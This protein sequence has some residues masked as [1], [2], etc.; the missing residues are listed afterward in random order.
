MDVEKRAFSFVASTETPVRAWIPD[1]LGKSDE[2]GGVRFIEV[3]EV[4]SMDSIDLGRAVVMPLVDAH[5]TFSI[6]SQLGSVETLQ[7]EVI[8]GLGRALT[9][10]TRFVP[11][12]GSLAEAM[13]EGHY[14]QLSIGYLVRHH[15][16][17]MREGTMPLATATDWELQEVSFAAR[18]LLRAYGAGRDAESARQ[19]GESLE[20]LRSRN[21]TDE[22]ID[23]MRAARRRDELAKWVRDNGR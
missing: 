22:I 13:A 11:S 6:D 9:G 14:R 19:T 18:I 2:H 7:V 3:D 21:L 1:P 10:S 23:E 12:R 17:E 15:D 8:E 16:S 20:A 4:L 5:N